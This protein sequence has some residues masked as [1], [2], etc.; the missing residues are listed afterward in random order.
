ME[1]GR[2]QIVWSDPW[3]RSTKTSYVQTSTHIG[4]EN[5]TVQDLL[6][7]SHVSWNQ[8]LIQEIFIPNDAQICCHP[9]VYME[10]KE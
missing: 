4:L 1:V 7:P 3:L 10:T 8:Q 6:D 2:R 9:L 5:M